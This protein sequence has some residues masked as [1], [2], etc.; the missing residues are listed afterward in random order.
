[1]NPE[2]TTATAAS[3]DSGVGRA[4]PIGLLLYVLPLAFA[5]RLAALPMLAHAGPDSV[6]YL[7]LAQQVA[8]GRGYTLP[9]SL[10]PNIDRPPLYPLILAVMTP[11]GAYQIPAVLVL[12]AFV[13]ALTACLVG[14]GAWLVWRRHQV[15]LA[16]TGM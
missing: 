7:L 14:V 1:M 10:E 4:V 2:E 16:A 3:H 13:D 8:E 5:L 12:Q 15:S 6:D 9:G 11:L